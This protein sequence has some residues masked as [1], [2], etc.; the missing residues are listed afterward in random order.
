MCLLDHVQYKY[1][2]PAFENFLRSW[3]HPLF[4]AST[5]THTYIHCGFVACRC[6]K[7]D[8]QLVCIHRG[9]VQVVKHHMIY[10]HERNQSSHNSFRCLRIIYL[11]T[12]L[13]ERN[14]CFALSPRRPYGEY[15]RMVLEHTHGLFIT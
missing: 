14:H 10:S 8:G 11:N 2:F 9:S 6:S 5:H 7:R 3:L 15:K 4:L 1:N 13:S 12:M